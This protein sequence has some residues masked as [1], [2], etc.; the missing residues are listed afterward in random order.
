MRSEETVLRSF[1]RY[2]L[3]QR[4]LRDQRLQII[5]LYRMLVDGACEPFDQQGYE[6]TLEDFRFA[7]SA[8]EAVVSQA[9][10]VMTTTAD[11]R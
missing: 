4:D 2:S 3:A 10:R 5:G 6:A 1:R 9:R 8:E 7:N 11:I